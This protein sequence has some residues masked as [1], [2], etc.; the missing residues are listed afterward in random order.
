MTLNSMLLRPANPNDIPSIVALERLPESTQFVGQWSEE[1]HRATLASPDARYFVNEAES[2]EA[3]QTD[4]G[5]LRAFAI[6]RGLKETSGSIEL[7]RLVVH[8]P[9]QGLGRQ[10]LA[11]LIR[12]AFDQF[13]AH[14]LFLDV[15]DDNLRAR[16]LYRKF[17]FVEEGLLR[18]AAR[19]NGQYCSLRLMSLLDRE[20]DARKP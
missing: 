8:P 4:T 16:H 6:L 11:E 13:H 17:D 18:E 15:F 12:I 14:R 20:Y 5:P 3:N 2:R 19:R 7:K 1:R 10:I 9:G